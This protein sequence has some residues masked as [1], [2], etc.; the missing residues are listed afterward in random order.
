MGL[1]QAQRLTT[2]LRTPLTIGIRREDPQRIWERR[3]PLT[4]DAV[5]ELVSKKNARVLVEPCDR[6]VFP[7]QEYVKAGASIAQDLNSAHILVGIKE[8]PLERLLTSPATSPTSNANAPYVPRTHLMFS[9]TAKGQPYNTPLLASFLANPTRSQTDAP[10]LPSLIDYELL[11]NEDDGKRTVGFGWFAG[12]AGV[13]ESLSAMAHAHLEIGIASPFLYTP[14]PHTLPSLERLRAALH[15]IGKQISYAGTPQ[16]LGPFV[17]G[18][19]GNGNVSQGCLSMLAELPIQKVAVKDLHELVT[20]SKTDLRKIYLVHAQPEE[21]LLNTTGRK[22]ERSDYYQH[23]ENYRSV[24]AEKVA[25]YLTLF[26]NGVG[27]SKSFPRLMTDQQLAIAL[28]RARQLR[29]ARFMSIGDISCDIEG[30]LQFMTEATTLSS[31]FYQ[32]RPSSLPSHLPSVQVMSVDILPA[33]IPLDASR[34]FSKALM[35]YMDSLVQMYTRNNFKGKFA[36]ALERATIAA[37]GQLKEDH[38]WLQPAV[39]KWYANGAAGANV[40]ESVDHPTGQPATKAQH[41]PELKKVLLLGSGMVAG[42]VVDKIAQRTDVQLMIASNSSSEIQRLTSGHADVQSKVIDVGNRTTYADLIEQADVVISL[43][44]VALHTTI[45]ELCIEYRKHL[46]TASYISEGMKAL[47]DRATQADVLLL[48][49]IGLDPGIDHC[50]AIS[51]IN[52]LHDEK[53]EIVSFT[54]FCGGLP[55]PEVPTVPLRYKFSWSPRGVLTAALNPARYRLNSKTMEVAGTQLLRSSFP[56][57]PISSEFTLEGIPNRDS[58][59]YASTYN[60]GESSSM[61][62]LL[63][64]TLRYPG[65]SALMYCFKSIGLLATEKTVQFDRWASFIPQ[66]LGIHLNAPVS[67]KDIPSLLAGL[68]P[69]SDIDSFTHALEW[70]SLLPPST[71]G[72]VPSPM[73]PIPSGPMTPLDVFAYLLSFKLRYLPNERDMVILSHEVIAKH[74]GPMAPEEVHTSTLVTYGTPKASAMARTVGIPVA[75]AALSIVDDRVPIRGVHGPG[76]RSIY[77]TVLDGLEEAGLSMKESNI[78]GLLPSIV[79]KRESITG[80]GGCS[81]TRATWTVELAQKVSKNR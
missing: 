17:I 6:R 50:S 4:P 61:R 12:V 16:A 25:P 80:G 51:L 15:D 73:P 63:R 70:L 64:G 9:H 21:Y 33:S 40:T 23:P 30:G 8:T 52:K 34:H 66:C 57:I 2:T 60:L 13:L 32:V 47:H 68:V 46:V 62:T 41:N 55:A 65:F 3:A 54:S 26:L 71:I 37:G 31:P 19:T 5:H 35:P 36:R 81:K 29:G 11:T 77:P 24:F 28:E 56:K 48:N 72:F 45:A 39:D 44:P 10:L 27:W 69:P 1:S 78:E 76:D 58:I 18:L 79:Q 74:S 22:Y 67:Q 75:I 38:R 42:P 43:L 59:P 20:N 53:K 14:R 49:E 7:P